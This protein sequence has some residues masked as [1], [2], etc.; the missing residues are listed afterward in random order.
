MTCSLRTVTDRLW[1]MAIVYEHVTL[2][3]DARPPEEYDVSHVV[4]ALR[5]EPDGSDAQQTL[6][7][8]TS[9]NTGTRHG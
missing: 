9:S 6:E 8:I 7:K 2:L 5:V 4:G 1:Y 3:Q